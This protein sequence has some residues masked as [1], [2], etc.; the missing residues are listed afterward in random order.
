M[1]ARTCPPQAAAELSSH[2]ASSELQKLCTV[3][4]Y[5]RAQERLWESNSCVAGAPTELPL[6]CDGAS[7][8]CCAQGLQGI[9]DPE[10]GGQE[11][12]GWRKAAGGGFKERRSPCWG[13]L[14]GPCSRIKSFLRTK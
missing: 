12:T 10:G 4:I 3:L 7:Q 6:R 5:Q 14:G 11:H 8:A 1:C 2:G 9:P 13:Q